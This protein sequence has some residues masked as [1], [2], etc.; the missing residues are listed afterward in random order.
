MAHFLLDIKEDLT[1]PSANAKT[2]G[3]YDLAKGLNELS[4]SKEDGGQRETERGMAG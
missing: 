4:T 1:R 2:L 3:K